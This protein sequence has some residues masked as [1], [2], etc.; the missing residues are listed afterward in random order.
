MDYRSVADGGT[1][2]VRVWKNGKLLAELNDIQ[3]LKSKASYADRF[4][5]FTY[6]NGGKPDGSGSLPSKDQYLFV[7]DLILTTDTPSNHDMYGNPMIG[8]ISITPK[9]PMSLKVK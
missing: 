5:I 2:R 3:T 8:D 6:W 4:L 1:S 9:P 7:D